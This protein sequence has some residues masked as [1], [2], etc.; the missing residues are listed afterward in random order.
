VILLLRTLDGRDDVAACKQKR[1]LKSDDSKPQIR[2]PKYQI[3]PGR[4][5]NFVER[6]SRSD[7]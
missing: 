4:Y 3:G 5:R 2:N 7:G 6:V 1:I